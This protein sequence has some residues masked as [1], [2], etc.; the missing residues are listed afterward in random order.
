MILGETYASL[1]EYQ[2][3]QGFL[4]ASFIAGVSSIA[5]LGLI[6]IADWL[7]TRVVREARNDFKSFKAI[8]LSNGH[9]HSSSTSTANPSNSI[10]INIAYFIIAIV[11]LADKKHVKPEQID[12]AKLA[13]QNLIETTT[14]VKQDTGIKR[15]EKAQ[16]LKA[17]GR[18]FTAIGIVCGLSAI[19]VKPDSPIPDCQPVLK[20]SVSKAD[21]I[22]PEN[23]KTPMPRVLL[24]PCYS[25]G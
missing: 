4:V 11:A 12:A 25:R 13:N 18:V 3:E 5:S 23:I 16:K 6:S 17:W 14:H 21:L 22:A 15:K 19:I 8:G 1:R 20:P 7:D 24:I 9:L 10:F 2:S